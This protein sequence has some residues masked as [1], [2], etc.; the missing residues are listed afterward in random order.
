MTWGVNLESSAAVVVRSVSRDVFWGAN[1]ATPVSHMVTTQPLADT[2]NLSH[3]ASLRRSWSLARA[4]GAGRP[5]GRRRL[6]GTSRSCQCRA[7][8]PVLQLLQTVY[9]G[10]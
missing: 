5:V 8:A 10:A 3:A 4:R 6:T 7:Q 2:D 9:L 1:E